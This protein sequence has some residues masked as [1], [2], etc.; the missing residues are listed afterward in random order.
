M[1]FEYSLIP[2]VSF[3]LYCANNFKADGIFVH[4][5]VMDGTFIISNTD[6]FFCLCVNYDLCFYCVAFF[7]PE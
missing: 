4:R 5:E 7:L 6:N 2:A 3:D 1:E